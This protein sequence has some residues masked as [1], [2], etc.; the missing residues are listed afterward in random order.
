MDQT[1]SRVLNN[2]QAAQAAFELVGQSLDDIK[3]SP[4]D[5]YKTVARQIEVETPQVSQATSFFTQMW[6]QVE[7]L[8]SS[9]ELSPKVQFSVME[10]VKNHPFFGGKFS[11]LLGQV[12]YSP[13]IGSRL[14]EVLK[15]HPLFG[16]MYNEVVSQFE[17][18]PRP[19]NIMEILK[20]L[21]A[22]AAS[23]GQELKEIETV[24]EQVMLTEQ[25]IATLMLKRRA[26]IGEKLAEY[27]G[28]MEALQ[29]GMA[30]YY[31]NFFTEEE[32][33]A[34]QVESAMRTIELEA[35]AMGYTLEQVPRTKD[36]FRNL[37]ESLNLTTE[38]GQRMFAKLMELSGAFALV[39]ESMEAL[40]ALAEDV[41][42]VIGEIGEEGAM[43]IAELLKSLKPGA[44]GSDAWEELDTWMRSLGIETPR[45]SEAMYALLTSGRLTSVQM[46]AL[47]ER[48]DELL[49]A[50]AYLEEGLSGWRA[51]VQT[52][53]SDLE[54]SVAAEKEAINATYQARV[55]ALNAEKEAAN[56]AH[57]ERIAALNDER[58]AAQEAA[59][60]VGSVLS[61]ITSALSSFRGTVVDEFSRAAA[62][63]MLADWARSRQ[64]PSSEDLNRV[65]AAA[66]SGAPEQFRTAADYAAYQKSTMANLIM[67]E[68][69]GQSQ[70]SAAEQTVQAIDAR[71]EQANKQHEQ[72][73][74]FL[75]QQIQQAAEWRDDE[76]GRLDQI[77]EDAK[78]A[79]EIALGTY[80]ATVSVEEAMR[81][82][83]AVISGQPG[84]APPWDGPVEPPGGWDAGPVA[85]R[86]T[87]AEVVELRTE[88]ALLR[89]SLT[90]LGVSEAAS[91]KSI[92]DRLLK[93]ELQSQSGEGP[94]TV[95]R[96]S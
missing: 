9:Q 16:N 93:W 19:S 33:R 56:L 39:Y 67:L 28:G 21:H 41:G 84:A 44:N 61:S 3:L 65:L 26:E 24:Y 34:K 43:K 92:D 7:E 91:L 79:A 66:T 87:T 31:E 96:A 62:S 11:E 52:A 46:L 36:E 69:S 13:E 48:S 40:K 95:V 71:I 37:V 10:A 82:V 58:T 42:K 78:R 17:T 54:R 70:L 22:N 35:K 6:G 5:M 23:T 83:Y 76:L 49:A 51:N 68:R 30:T 80:R 50:F 14:E 53:I 18:D 12:E 73:I 27:A 4:E 57:S 94:V 2:I 8:L 47:A 85:Q 29:A 90:N 45:T 75:D 55:D 60:E 74:G 20:K 38:S 77:V 89:E 1:L 64:L 63:A 25:E 86:E 81:A 72:Y 15:S 32:R 88:V 59:Q